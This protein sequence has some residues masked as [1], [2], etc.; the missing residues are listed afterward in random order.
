[1]PKPIELNITT[2]TQADLE[3]TLLWHIELV[4]VC[5]GERVTLRSKRGTVAIV[6]LNDLKLLEKYRPLLEAHIAIQ[7]HS[8][9][10]HRQ[11]LLD[12]IKK[13]M[14]IPFL[15]REVECISL[16]LSGFSAKYIATILGISYRTVETHVR[17]AYQKIGCFGRQELL[18][19][20]CEANL[21]PRWWE[22]A[23]L[24]LDIE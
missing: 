20:M 9:P 7:E 5:P 18:E 11:L 19:M 16:T 24:L 13:E 4:S 3:E 8:V 17:N 21:L 1:M 10:L 12:L 15:D 22:F 2:I 6:S 14:K 23:R